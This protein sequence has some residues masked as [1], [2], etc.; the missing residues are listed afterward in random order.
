M[1]LNDSPDELGSLNEAAIILLC[2]GEDRAADVLRCFSREEVL[3]IARAI[4]NIGGV[5]VDAV[6]LALQHFFSEYREQSGI[7]GASRA[8]LQKALDLA[9]G[10]DVAHAALNSIYGDSI[11]TKLAALSWASP[12]WLADYI[13]KEHIRIQA[14][15]IAL[16]PPTQ[17]SKVLEAL[18]SDVQDVVL[19]NV[20]KLDEVGHD[21]L[22]EIE[23]L[24][25]HCLASLDR[26]GTT[27][28]GT[29]QAAE[30]INRLP[31]GRSRLMELLRAHDPTVAAEIEASM[32]GFDILARQ[33]DATLNRIIEMVPLE[34][35]AIALQG[36]ESGLLE[37]LQR[38][39]PRRQA[40]SLKEARDRTRPLPATRVE[41]L[42]REI[43]TGVK[44]LANDKEIELQLIEED[45]VS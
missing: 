3:K 20:A 28:E 19:F 11:R 38:A 18:P 33:D 2:I 25:L 34:Q 27:V 15:F 30:I 7:H 39:M 42:R 16:L 45:T 5:K 21:L 17:G 9:L 23:Q 32:Y 36:D 13:A 14:V 41:H 6:K 29:R 35:W 1:L 8:Y 4:A 22:A 10:H 24:V 44:A 31:D 43:M 40:Q 12:R 37:A 26:Q